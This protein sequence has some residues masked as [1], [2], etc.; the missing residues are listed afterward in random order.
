MTAGRAKGGAEGGLDRI[1]TRLEV[2]R[3]RAGIPLLARQ[4]VCQMVAITRQALYRQVALVQ[5]HLVRRAGEAQALGNHLSIFRVTLIPLRQ[6]VLEALN[7]PWVEQIA[8]PVGIGQ[9]GVWA[10][11]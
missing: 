6:G 1:L 4:V 7:T 3:D 9:E 5:G 2:Q 11:W 10:R 8:M